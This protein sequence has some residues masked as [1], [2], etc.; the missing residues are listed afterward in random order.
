MFDY[1]YL[2][3]LIANRIEENP[4]L[5]YKAGGALQKDD[6]KV[7][8]ITKDVSSFANSNGGVLIY[9]IAEDQSDK[10][11]PGNI[12]AVDA[13]VISKEWLEQIINSKIRPRI[14]GLK[15]HVVAL[16]EDE[17]Q[18]V[19]ILEIPKGNTAHQADDKKYYRRHN[20]MVE[21]LYDHEIRDIMNRQKEPVIKTLFIVAKKPNVTMHNNDLLRYHQP[22]Y[23]YS[24][25]VY[26]ENV[27]K[28]YAKYVNIVLSLPERCVDDRAADEDDGSIIEKRL[29]NKV[30]D[31]VE[32]PD[33]SRTMFNID[34]LNRPKQ[35]G[36]ARH[37]PL[38]PGMHVKL[39][40]F[41]LTPQALQPGNELKW[42]IYADNAEP[43][44]GSIEISAIDRL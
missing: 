35:Y 2:L 5:E 39:D 29:D 30:R 9:G 24:L 42:T 8:E 7:I 3:K 41:D 22:L 25:H 21:P 34:E 26:I 27:G 6:K 19:Y 15:I 31:L 33:N 10:R 17:R 43:K 23:P 20:F 12:D 13:K 16:P 4:E 44:I 14:H 11:F 38:L 1:N 40:S 32:P 36:P 37:E 28:M 18:V